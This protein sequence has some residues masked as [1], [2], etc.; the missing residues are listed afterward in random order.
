MPKSSAANC[1]KPFLIEAPIVDC[2]VA[3]LCRPDMPLYG[4]ATAAAICRTVLDAARRTC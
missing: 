3:W 1:H 4:M 2:H